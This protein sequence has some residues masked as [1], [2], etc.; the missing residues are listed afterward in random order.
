MRV[1]ATEVTKK[2]ADIGR[3]V[4]SVRCSFKISVLFEAHYDIL[5]NISEDFHFVSV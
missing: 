5:L 3:G 2:A 1:L 4:L